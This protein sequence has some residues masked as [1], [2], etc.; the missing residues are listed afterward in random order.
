MKVI[1]LIVLI[2]GVGGSLLY[3]ILFK[4]RIKHLTDKTSENK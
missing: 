1:T 4:Y 2:L 3:F